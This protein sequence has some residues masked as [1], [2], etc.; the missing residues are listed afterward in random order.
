MQRFFMAPSRGS[1]HGAAVTE[2]VCERKGNAI[3][4]DNILNMTDTQ[5]MLKNRFLLQEE[6][7]CSTKS[8]PKKPQHSAALSYL[9]TGILT[10]T[11]R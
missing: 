3:L 1:W 11:L 8:I 6:G 10:T 9:M 4:H 2:G 7:F 5:S